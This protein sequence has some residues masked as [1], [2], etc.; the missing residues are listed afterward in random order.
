MTN[1]TDNDND[2][3][4]F[5]TMIAGACVLVSMDDDTFY[6]VSIMEP[7]TF[8]PIVVRFYRMGDMLRA[9]AVY[10]DRHDGLFGDDGAF[11]LIFR[12]AH[13]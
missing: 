2:N 13:G 10:A 7:D 9:L 3:I 6:T 8:R 11:D 12:T 4:V 5:D 1:H